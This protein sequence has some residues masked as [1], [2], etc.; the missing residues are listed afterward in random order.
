MKKISSRG[1]VE[2]LIKGKGDFVQID[3]LSNFLKG[4]L[5]IDVKRFVAVKLAEIYARRKLYANAA[6][7]YNVASI[8]SVAFTEKI[9]LH[10]REAEMFVKAGEYIY[11]DEA[12]KKAMSQANANQ[13]SEI[14]FVIKEFYKKQAEQYEK[15][16]RRAHAARIYEKLMEMNISELERNEVKK[17]LLSLY[18]KLGKV[19]E[20]YALREGSRK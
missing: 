1:E 10:M 2:E 15:E 13:K 11:A 5:P 20:Y 3:Y 4:E 14:Y 9:K 17:R 18:E 19:K 7:M 6:K 16:L 12:M 8:S